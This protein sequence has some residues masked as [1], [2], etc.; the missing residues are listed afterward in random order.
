MKVKTIRLYKDNE[1]V[2]V[3]EKRV[4]EFSDLGYQ[5]EPVGAEDTK[6][7]DVGE[8][9][10]GDGGKAKGRKAKDEPVSQDAGEAG[11]V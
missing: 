5:T 4:G 11:G 7:S 3:D 1:E 2:I 8:S 10:K 6:S 9:G